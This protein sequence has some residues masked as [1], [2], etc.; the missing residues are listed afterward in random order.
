[1]GSMNGPPDPPERVAVFGPE[2]EELT[3]YPFNDTS[4][5]L[6]WQA[7]ASAGNRLGAGY[8]NY[9]GTWRSTLG[10]DVVYYVLDGSLDMHV[11]ESTRTAVR[12]DIVF[13]AMGT[14]VVYDTPEGCRIFWATS[15][16][17][18]EAVSDFDRTRI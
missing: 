1:M 6:V 7:V 3:A 10:D 9:Q 8:S 2:Q 14:E 18:W 5:V 16:A 12:G 15:P 17:D 11:G 4:Q 13:L